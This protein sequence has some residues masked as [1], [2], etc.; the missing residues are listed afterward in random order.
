MKGDR[1]STLPARRIKSELN[2]V[3]ILQYR[4]WQSLLSAA[5]RRTGIHSSQVFLVLSPAP[6]IIRVPKIMRGDSYICRER[7]RS[8]KKWP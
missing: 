7:Q 8:R 2:I 5:P 4:V 1:L 6:Y 3:F